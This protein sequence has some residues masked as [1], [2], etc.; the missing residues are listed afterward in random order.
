VVLS[1]SSGSVI[2]LILLLI[3]VNFFINN[4]EKGDLTMKKNFKYQM[5][6]AIIMNVIYSIL[7]TLWAIGCSAAA[8]MLASSQ[9]DNNQYF[10][11]EK[12]NA[13]FGTRQQSIKMC[14]QVTLEPL[15]INKLK[16][17]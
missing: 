9:Y 10:I 1:I 13:G 5:P 17:E 12:N 4:K 14:R 7:N 6:T 3:L 15:V 11:Y 2:A 8:A 16:N